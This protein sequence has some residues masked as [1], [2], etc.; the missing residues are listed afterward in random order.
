MGARVI[1]RMAAAGFKPGVVAYTSLIKGHCADGELGL[2]AAVLDEM[3]R[4]AQ[5]AI[6]KGT[7]YPPEH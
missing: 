5:T 7:R 4:P 2:A 1:K 6:Q 3:A